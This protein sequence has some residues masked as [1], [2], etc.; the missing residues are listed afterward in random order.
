MRDLADKLQARYEVLQKREKRCELGRPLHN[1][2][3]PSPSLP[4]DVLT[5]DQDA[6]SRSAG[7]IFWNT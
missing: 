4:V 6:L 7:K 5:M 1:C 2:C 3:L